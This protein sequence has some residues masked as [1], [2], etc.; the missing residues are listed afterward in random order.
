MRPRAQPSQLDLAELMSDVAELFR[1]E[2]EQKS[3]LFTQAMPS[4]MAIVEAD[5][6]P[7]RHKQVRLVGNAVKFTNAGGS[8]TPES[9]LSAGTRARLKITRGRVL[10]G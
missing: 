5:A 8:L 2:C 3:L 10:V 7:V 6:R 9:N 4:G 1:S